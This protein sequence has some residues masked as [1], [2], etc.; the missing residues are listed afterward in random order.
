MNVVLGMVAV[1]RDVTIM[2]AAISVS[3]IY[4]DLQWIPRMTNSALVS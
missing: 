2:L 3:V 4:Q 1:N